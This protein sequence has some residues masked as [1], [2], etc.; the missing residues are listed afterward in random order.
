MTYTICMYVAI[1]TSTK[2]IPVFCH[3]RSFSSLC[4]LCVYNINKKKK[5]E[6]E[7]RSKALEVVSPQKYCRRNWKQFLVFIAT[8]KYILIQ[9]GQ[10]NRLL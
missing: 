10:R 3:F 5:K 4:H 1:Q 6:K 9:N 8:H 7:N 2:H